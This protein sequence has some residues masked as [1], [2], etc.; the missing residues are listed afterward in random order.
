[1]EFKA[2]A[3]IERIATESATAV[4]AFGQKNFGEHLDYS[5]AS[6]EIVE[7]MLESAHSAY[8]NGQLAAEAVQQQAQF[9]G[10]YIGE[11]YRRNH[12]ADWGLVTSDGAKAVGLQSKSGVLFWPVT[13]VENRILNGGEDN[14]LHY[15]QLLVRKNGTPV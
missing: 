13:R 9:I 12:G 5:D 15:Y 2:I 7:R 8:R 10:S 11:T 1:M 6:I 4:V 14:V 3:D